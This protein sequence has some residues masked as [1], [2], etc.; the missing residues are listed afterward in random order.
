M[1]MRRWPAAEGEVVVFEGWY[2]EVLRREGDDRGVVL[3]EGVEGDCSG[4]NRRSSAGGRHCAEVVK[5]S[6]N[7]L[8]GA[9]TRRR[10]WLQ[11][12]FRALQGRAGSA[13]TSAPLTTAVEGVRLGLG[14][15]RC[16]DAGRKGRG[17]GW[18]LG[19]RG[20]LAGGCCCLCWPC[21]GGVLRRGGNGDDPAATPPPKLV[22]RPHPASNRAIHYSHLLLS[23]PP[24]HHAIRPFHITGDTW[25]T[26][27]L[28][29]QPSHPSLS[30]NRHPPRA[31]TRRRGA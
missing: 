7:R 23:S 25:N 12:N 19:R 18:L 6:G 22:S 11:W 10:R 30:H 17:V 3:A 15:C 29:H 13:G 14:C 8:A 5:R 20:W 28:R 31:R 24:Q 4:R 26:T 1:T 2:R 16:Q 21:G 27:I 9:G